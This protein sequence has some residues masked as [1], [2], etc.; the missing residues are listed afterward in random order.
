MFP[1]LSSLLSHAIFEQEL[2]CKM[3]DSPRVLK[4]RIHST[5]YHFLWIQVYFQWEI[6]IELQTEGNTYGQEINIKILGPASFPVEPY[7]SPKQMIKSYTPCLLSRVSIV[8]LPTRDSRDT[9]LCFF[10]LH[11][12]AKTTA[13]VALLSITQNGAVHSL[14]YAKPP[15]WVEHC[16]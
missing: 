3:S 13:S 2:I 15:S 12:V 16:R 4:G 14:C 11:P 8:H 10:Y 1:V 5:L 6:P 7:C 9:A